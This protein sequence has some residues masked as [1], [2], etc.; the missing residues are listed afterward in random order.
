M[1]KSQ[2]KQEQFFPQ[3]N[4]CTIFDEGFKVYQETIPGNPEVAEGKC[5]AI[6]QQI[7]ADPQDGDREAFVPGRPCEE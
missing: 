6:N 2:K 4:C 7:N 5:D 1:K 3:E